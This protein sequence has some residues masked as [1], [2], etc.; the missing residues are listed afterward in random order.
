MCGRYGFVHDA[1]VIGPL[2]NVETVKLE[3]RFNVAPS[4]EVPI[5]RLDDEHNRE[6]ALVQWGLLP[7]WVRDP[8]EFKASTIN[9]RADKVADSPSYREPFKRRRCLVPAS[10]FYEWKREGS[11][12]Q[13]YFI[14]YKDGRPLAFAGL[15]DHWERGDKVIESC[16]IITTSANGVMKDI[17]DRMPV[18][19][20][21]EAFDFWL[22]EEAATQEEL[23][24]LLVPYP[25]PEEMEAYPVSRAV[26][27]PRNDSGELVAR[28]GS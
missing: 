20:E 13:P 25:N 14:R 22:G 4:Q 26:N 21:P 27:S 1:S 11:S 3:P 9:A 18:I 19:L 23:L 7:H 24:D 2:F 28:I 17:H 6:M 15:W 10:G 8:K 12:K 16:T 5:I